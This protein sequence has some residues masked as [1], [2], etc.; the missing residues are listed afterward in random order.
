[1]TKPNTRRIWST[2]KKAKKPDEELRVESGSWEM[3]H[4]VRPMQ[5][6]IL[7]ITAIVFATIVGGI[8]LLVAP[9][10]YLGSKSKQQR[11]ALQS[12]NDYQEIAKAGVV[13]TRSMTNQSVLIRPDDARVPALLCSLAPRHITVNSNL[14]TMEFHGG[15]AHY[16]FRIRQADTNAALWSI[17]W[18]NEHDERFLTNIVSDAQ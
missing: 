4:E 8:V 6:T 15:I 12:R 3:V 14:V 11:Q 13:L 1:M 17:S 9:F 10:K 5:K 16:G 7:T 18:Y 2:C